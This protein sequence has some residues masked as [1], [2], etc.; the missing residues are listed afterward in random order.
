MSTSACC[1]LSL[2]SRAST[3]A[4]FALVLSACL[5]GSFGAAAQAP[6]HAVSASG[7]DTDAGVEAEEAVARDSPRASM[8]N[9]IALCNSGDYEGAA[10]YL[11]L[12]P[13]DKELG[14]Q[15][16]RR[17]KAVLDRKAWLD[18]GKLSSLA[19]GKTD[20][21]LSAYTDEVGQVIGV[22]GIPQPVRIVRRKRDVVR[23]L[24]SNATLAR[25]DGWY[26]QLDDRWV[27][28]KLPAPLLRTGPRS[29][30]YWQWLALP[31]LLIV[32]WLV[33]LLI[34]GVT[35]SVLGKLAARSKNAW[36]DALVSRLKPPAT[37]WWMLAV[38]YCLLPW[39]ALYEP[40]EKFVLSFM[41][42]L[43]LVG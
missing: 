20:D 2:C 25:V 31:L 19:T 36:D 29:L 18:V 16:A 11:E 39:L 41:H 26:E 9:Y 5:L 21:G 28:E 22:D 42:T 10:D 8:M 40:A 17:L 1:S 12:A 24:F 33:G 23:W 6:I 13:A 4:L 7:S 34:S 14:P 27:L 30:M 37:L 38:A 3:C 43:F 32:S 35:A 15:L